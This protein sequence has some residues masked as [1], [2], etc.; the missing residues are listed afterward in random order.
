MTLEVII[1]LG[2]L[3]FLFT[4]IAFQLDEKHNILKVLMFIFGILMMFILS[5]VSYE[6]MDFCEIMPRN[7]TVT[8]NTTSY[9]YTRECFENPDKSGLAGFKLM[10]YFVRILNWYVVIVMLLML[11][12]LFHFKPFE[13]IKRW[14]N[15]E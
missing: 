4:Y 10:N 11:F 12:D 3:S 9:E 7:S 5:K 15:R 14:F 2:I 6:A 1:G 13:Q 8:G